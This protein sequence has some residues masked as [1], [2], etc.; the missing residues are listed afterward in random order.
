MS[1]CVAMATA[2]G[3]PLP[4]MGER[5][6]KM[7]S[8]AERDLSGLTQVTNF[9]SCLCTYVVPRIEKKK[10]CGESFGVSTGAKK[11]NGQ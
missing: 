8:Q 1:F 7:L 10:I 2:G 3:C 6:E 4:P 5:V 9:T 11:K